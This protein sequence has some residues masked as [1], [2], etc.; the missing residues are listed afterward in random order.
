M[1]AE[2]GVLKI[3]GKYTGEHSCQTVISIKLQSSFIEITLRLGYSPVNLLHI[4]R[5][6]FYNNTF[7]WAASVMV[8]EKKLDDSFPTA[9]VVIEG[10]F[11]PFR[12][13]RTSSGGG[14]LLHIKNNITLDILYSHSVKVLKFFFWDDNVKENGSLFSCTYNPH[15]SNTYSNMNELEP[16]FENYCQKT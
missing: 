9:K 13:D 7:G 6:S 15:K 1:F 4:F 12:Q 10:Y 3:C 11:S 8:S 16:V 2:K 5:T 14:I